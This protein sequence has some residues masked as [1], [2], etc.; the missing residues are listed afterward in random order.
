M[1]IVE[2][3]NNSNFRI[4]KQIRSKTKHLLLPA[5]L[6]MSLDS[7]MEQLRVVYAKLKYHAFRPAKQLGISIQRYRGEL[8]MI[9]RLL[10]RMS[11]I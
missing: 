4:S 6:S 2:Y 10:Q 1:E 11:A 9:Q 8:L 5:N 3:P 7:R